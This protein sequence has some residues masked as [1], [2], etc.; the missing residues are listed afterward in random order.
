[1][2]IKNAASLTQT[3]NDKNKVKTNSTVAPKKGGRMIA[4]DRF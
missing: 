2:P 3:F 1:M 4:D